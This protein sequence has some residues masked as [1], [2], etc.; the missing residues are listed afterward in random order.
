MHRSIALRTLFLLVCFGLSSVNAQDRAAEAA[1]ALLERVI[2]GHSASFVFEEIPAQGDKD[3]FEVE[4][5]QGKIH[6]R[7]NSGVALASGLNWYLTKKCQ[8][9]VSLTYRQ[10]DL[11]TPLPELKAKVRKVTEF[12]YRNFFNYCTFAYTMAWWDWPQWEHLIDYMALHGVNMP[13]AITGQEAVWQVVCREL[14]LNDQQIADFLVG[15]AFLPWGWMGNI[16]GMAGPL[17]QAWIDRHKGLQQKILKRQ[18]SLGM[19]PVLQ[20]FTG[21][22]PLALKEV[23]PAA[24]IHQTTPWAGMPG[25]YF[26]DPQDPLFQKIG[27]RFIEVQTDLYGTDHLYDADCF[28]EV[29]PHTNDP[30]FLSKVGDSV[31]KAMAN[32]D[33]EATWVFQGWFLFWQQNFWKAPQARALFS[34]VPEEK[35]IGLDLYCERNPVWDKTEAFYGKPWVWNVICNLGQKVNMS[36]ALHTMQANLSKAMTSPKAGKLSGIGVMMEG[37]G[38]NPVVQ[39][40]VLSKTWDPDPVD[41]N[42]WITA[43]ARRRYGTE[44][45]QAQQAWLHLLAGPYSRNILRGSRL[46][47]TPGLADYDSE[48]NQFGLDY[49]ATHTVEACRALLA[50]AS[51]LAGVETY[52]FDLVHTCRE[53]MVNLAN[54]LIREMKWAY[55][56]QDQS[57]FDQASSRL[58]GL[59]EDLDQLCNTHEQFQLGP[60]LAKARQ[61]ATSDE[62]EALYELNAR[63]QVTMW[64]PSKDS[65]LRDYASKDWAGLYGDFYLKRWSLY[66]D[67]LR[68][69]WNKE[70]FNQ[71]AFFKDVKDFEFKWINARTDYPSQTVGDSV[72]VAQAM[73]KKYQGYYG[74]PNVR[75][76]KLI[77]WPKSVQDKEAVTLVASSFFISDESL[78]P[79]LAVLN[80]GLTRIT[81]ITG[82]LVSEASEAGIVF[83]FDDRLAHAVYTL[84]IQSNSILVSAAD[85]QGFVHGCASLLQLATPDTHA[86]IFP[87]VSVEDQ[88]AYPYRGL[89]LDLA[90]FWHPVHTIKETIDLAFLYKM[91]FLQ[92]HLSDHRAFTFPSRAYPQLRSTFPDGRRRHYTVDELRDLVSYAAQRGIVIVPEIEMPGHSACMSRQFPEAFGTLDPVSGVFKNTGGVINMANEKA[93]EVLDILLGEVAEIFH[94]SPYIHIGA[95]EVAPGSL[96]SLVE[97]GP[98]TKTHNLPRAQAGDTHELYAHFVVR[99]NDIV[100][101]HGKTMIA[102]E[103]FHGTG[104]EQARIPTDIVVMAWNNTFNPPLQL[105]E[106][107]FT[108]I[109]CSWTPLYLV[110]P[111]NYKESQ[112]RT[113]AWHPRE[114]EH[115]RK[116]PLK[117]VTE[118]VDL[119]GGQICFW[120]QTYDAVIPQLREH[121]PVVA[122]RLWNAESKLPFVHF[123]QRFEAIDNH[124]EKLLRPVHIQAEGLL[125]DS[126]ISRSFFEAVTVTL[127]SDQPGVLRYR[128]DEN[129]GQFP[130]ANS[131]LYSEPLVL[132]DSQVVTAALFNDQGQRISPYTQEGY[133]NV[134]PVYHYRVLGP[135]PKRGWQT[136]PDFTT[137]RETRQGVLGYSD[138]SRMTA[139]NRTIFAKLPSLGHIDT[140][141]KDQF[142][143]FAMELSGQ[144]EIPA[145]GTYQFRMKSPQGMARVYLDEACVA[146]SK[147][148]GAEAVYAGQIKAGTYTL[149]IE[150]FY[151]QTQNQLNIQVLGPGN[152][153]YVSLDSLALPMAQWVPEAKLSRLPKTASFG[154]PGR[155]AYLSLATDKPVTCSGGTQPPNGPS[156][157]VDADPTNRSGW[158]CEASG[159]WLQV[160]L[161][162][163]KTIQRIRLHTYHDGR[164]TYTYII[165]VSE[166]GQD[167]VEVVNQRE[168]STV[169]TAKGFEHRFAP[170]PARYVRVTMLSNSA[171]PGVHI[172][173]VMVYDD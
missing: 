50:C 118:D 47:Y 90:R 120:E 159:H 126:Q 119:L 33:P 53:M 28:N 127:Q 45:A 117:R 149:R 141:P 161:E 54:T 160:D 72:K 51:E 97:Y 154:D 108:L 11:P 123:Q 2:P 84:N 93:Y 55:E 158:H 67:A 71:G 56:A 99:M 22:V 122:E 9:Q 165:E 109:N 26:L 61:W 168:N 6:I 70:A 35:L 101:G 95:D 134:T 100:K 20:G 103:G 75:G 88:P 156:H 107:G 43:Y 150:Y 144:L 79:L 113:Y 21:H 170:R 23:F 169:S 148:L 3:L 155:E 152:E 137:L 38:Y 68:K 27:T 121:M 91:N 171:N 34:A 138:P 15:P 62:E 32:A 145:S 74:L 37:F 128:V 166:N 41:L 146:G 106:N 7:G 157:A 1:H 125:D 12:T 49:D 115:R 14:G 131:A 135:V 78:A 10:L 85:H 147:R 136:M 116:A 58:L 151:R 86:W 24:T 105:A 63:S 18:R 130:D 39:E 173:E 164:R 16:D 59:L 110:P 112:E 81:G 8:C 44:N 77:P 13:L 162:E 42:E 25:T 163:V 140:Q 167:F 29:N 96:K 5:V 31:Y 133:Q 17:P 92:L 4:T 40:F 124:A 129:W 153:D 94:T 19:T 36:G 98:Y 87:C 83:R 73:L 82:K 57:S 64:Q 89:L 80:D 46:N 142:C 52:R 60:W 104:T 76:P 114:F 111:Q 139:L 65:H 132:N 69:A 172:N 48:K 30:V 66:I 143:P 102:W